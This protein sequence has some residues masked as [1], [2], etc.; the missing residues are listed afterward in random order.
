MDQLV[1]NISPSP[2]KSFDNFIIGRNL[3]ILQ[4]LKQFNRPQSVYQIIFL[5]GIEGSGK[6]HLLNS[7]DNVDVKKIENIQ[8]FEEMEQASLF[9]LI[10]EI[11]Q[12]QKKIIITSNK[13]PDELNLIRGDL[14]SRLKWGLVLNL[15]PLSDID[16]FKVIQNQSKERGLKIN[17]NVI[18]YCINHLRRDLH[19]LINTLQALDELSLKSKRPIT[20][21][22]IKELQESNKI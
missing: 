4:V 19:T 18:K 3:E 20:I 9:N 22:F 10:N 17:D 11:K 1:L 14:T 5:W 6:T 15:K 16:K 2:S 12:N 8:S 13:S 21:N 7:I